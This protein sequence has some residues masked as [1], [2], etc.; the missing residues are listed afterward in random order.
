MFQITWLLFK[1]ILLRSCTNQRWLI[2]QSNAKG[3]DRN[4]GNPRT[5]LSVLI[6]LAEHCI[7]NCRL[8]VRKNIFIY[9]FFSENFAGKTLLD[10]MLVSVWTSAKKFSHSLSI[11]C[12]CLVWHWKHRVRWKSSYFIP[13][14][15]PDYRKFLSW[16][17]NTTIGNL[18]TYLFYGYEVEV[19]SQPWS[20]ACT[21]F[22]LTITHKSA[23]LWPSLF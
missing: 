8:I 14:E 15:G 21:W 12:Q 20:F 11:R 16:N 2:L 1:G 19:K 13:V 9:Y 18:F 17:K 6:T 22:S 10:G 4:K 23:Q 7:V 5:D 3:K